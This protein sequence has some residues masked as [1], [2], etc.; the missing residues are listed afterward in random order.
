MTENMT[1]VILTKKR[2]TFKDII[3]SF[4]PF[5]IGDTRVILVFAADICRILV[6]AADICGILIY[7]KHFNPHTLLRGPCGPQTD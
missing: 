6:F 4:L 1:K 7:T 2:K 5:S 3:F